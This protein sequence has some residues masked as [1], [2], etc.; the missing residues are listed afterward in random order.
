M[1][2]GS[3][4]MLE[5]V[6]QWLGRMEVAPVVGAGIIAAVTIVAAWV[7]RLLGGRLALALSRW[8]GLGIRTQLFEII[9]H[10]LWMSVLMIGALLEVQWLSLP[11]PADFLIT[12]AAQT[13]LAVLWAIVLGR[14]LALSCSRLS[15]YYAGAEELFRLTE[16][17]GVVVIAAVS[18]LII[19]SIWRINLTPLI[20]SAGLVGIVVGLAAKD[21]LGNFFGG[22]SVFLDRPFRRGDYIVLDSGQRGQVINIGLRSTRILTR[23]DILIS[24]PN[25]MIV[26]TKIV[27]E[28]A[29]N[30][31]MR[32]RLKISV[33]QGS[34]HEKV[35]QALHKIAEDNELV[36]SKPAPRVRFRGFGDTSFDF[37]LLCWIAN[38]RDK[39]KTIDQL[40]T[41]AVEEFIRTGISLVTP[42]RE[43]YIYQVSK[44]SD[45]SNAEKPRSADDGGPVEQATA[46]PSDTNVI[47][48]A[49]RGKEEPEVRAP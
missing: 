14:T 21:T 26:S 49:E 3:I 33:L 18:A 25:A 47:E 43:L 42:Q 7:M 9:R 10:P 15:A 17:I 28:S 37:E 19:L 36:L 24:I 13:G 6:N 8:S 46:Y 20:A 16:N 41:A 45:A 23:D 31:I 22:I 1:T 35:R 29:P 34:D 27:N 44:T 2:D 39:G 30:R 12:G 40:N 4:Q 38:P 11:H 5:L 32:I 48:Q